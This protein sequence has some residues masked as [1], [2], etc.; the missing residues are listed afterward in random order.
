MSGMRNIDE[1][2]RLKRKKL[3]RNEKLGLIV[4]KQL[5]SMIEHWFRRDDEGESDENSLWRNIR[6]PYT[7]FTSHQSISAR[8]KS[9]DK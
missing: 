1:E 5:N 8:D 6:Q 9:Y 2:F 3:S 7:Q 4:A